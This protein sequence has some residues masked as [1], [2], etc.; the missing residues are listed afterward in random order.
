MQLTLQQAYDRITELEELI[1][2]K[3]QPLHVPGMGPMM[4]Q[5]LG[6]LIKR[7]LVEREMAYRAIYGARPEHA[8]PSSMRIIDTH[9]ARLRRLLAPHNIV[10]YTER[11]LGYYIDKNGKD[12]LQALANSQ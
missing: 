4:N 2:I 7:Q 5:L 12:K 3:P 6:L 1:G 11:Q 8:Q 9:I 10:I